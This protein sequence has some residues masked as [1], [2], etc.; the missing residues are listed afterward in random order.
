M[1]TKSV[2][3]KLLIRPGAT[4]WSSSACL[5]LVEPLP[6]GVH[7]VDSPDDA[8]TAIIFADSAASVRATLIE[9][10]VAL[11]RPEV[12]WVAYPKA[13]WADINRDSL[14]PILAE[15]GMRPIS[16]VAID[17]VWSALRFRPLKPGEAPFSGGQ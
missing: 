2:A 8:T 7:R 4:V 9:H 3:E 17:D 16:Q 14:W 10:G 1:S 15:H 13:N 5:D 12:F 6:H 11:S